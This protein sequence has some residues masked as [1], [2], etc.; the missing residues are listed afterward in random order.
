MHIED[1]SSKNSKSPSK[2][3]QSL[4]KNSIASLVGDL[5]GDKMGMLDLLKVGAAGKHLRKHNT[6]KSS[7][8]LSGSEIR[9]NNVILKDGAGQ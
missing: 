7:S 8:D 5:A 6:L 9:R 3:D 2:M 1:S 4:Q